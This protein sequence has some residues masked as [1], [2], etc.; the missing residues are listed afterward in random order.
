MTDPQL[1]G[2]PALA[3]VADSSPARCAVL[4]D[5]IEHSLSPA[6]HTAAYAALGLGWR[7]DAVRVPAG[8]LAGFLAAVEAERDSGVEWRGLSLTMPLKRELLG[9][10]DRVT[11]T[12]RRAGAAN[13]LWWDGGLRVADNTDVPGAAAALGE[14]CGVLAGPAALLG[15]G[16][17]AT[18]VGLALISLGVTDLDV[19]ARDPARAAETVATLEAAGARV[20]VGVLDPTEATPLEAAILV[21]TVPAEA[22]TPALLA[23]A[24]AVP[25]VFEV[26]YEPW[27]TPLADAVLA[28]P[29]RTL[30][31]GLDLLAHQALLQL[32]A[33]TAPDVD[34]AEFARHVDVSL[35]RRAGET[36]LTG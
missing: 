22:Q 36:A 7:Y 25:V 32:S 16:A 15:G 33:F 9:L 26:R 12:A 34:A 27:P 19:L 14:R 3:G 11:D 13:T 4:G 35:L 10:A 2:G 20:R 1:S 30:V 28:D 6:L 21:S 31:S 17:T 29:A 8:A 18:S 23:R 5:P 24:G